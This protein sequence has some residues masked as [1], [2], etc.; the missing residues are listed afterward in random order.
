MPQLK[1]CLAP[2]PGA[3]ANG[4]SSSVSSSELCTT[5]N[6]AK[7]QYYHK[8]AYRSSDVDLFIYG[9]EKEEDANNKLKEIYLAVRQAIPG[10]THLKWFFLSD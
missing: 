1:A 7:R 8:E 5:D 3:A 6:I 4:T 9:F 10:S 2:L